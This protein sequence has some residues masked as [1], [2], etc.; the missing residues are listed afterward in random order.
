MSV[1]AADLHTKGKAKLL[2][3]EIRLDL[4]LHRL[5]SVK[6]ELIHFPID[7]HESCMCGSSI[8][9]HS[10]GSGH[11]PVSMADHAILNMISDV[12]K[13]ISELENAGK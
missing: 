1:L 4:A 6:S 13:T 3:A 5:K 7:A 9:S 2:L 8:E 11:S 12:S 10:I